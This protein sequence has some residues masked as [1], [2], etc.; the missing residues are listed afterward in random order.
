MFLAEDIVIFESQNE[1]GNER[2]VQLPY[3]QMTKFHF[4]PP[5][6][7]HL[8][9]YLEYLNQYIQENGRGATRPVKGWWITH[10]SVYSPQIKKLFNFVVGRD[11]S[12]DNMTSTFVR[13]QFTQISLTQKQIVLKKIVN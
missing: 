5:Y 7:L 1:V 8:I 4:H 6:Q 12:G 11:C 10:R 9:E 3:Q 13:I 2:G